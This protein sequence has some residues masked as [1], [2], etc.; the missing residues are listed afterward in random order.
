MF[1]PNLRTLS[2]RILPISAILSKRTDSTAEIPKAP[3]PIIPPYATTNDL[4]WEIASMY[5][6]QIREDKPG[7]IALYLMEISAI[8]AAA[9]SRND[10]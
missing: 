10:Q 6:L 8:K 9:Y 2:S 4:D 7:D 3:K 5:V 1:D